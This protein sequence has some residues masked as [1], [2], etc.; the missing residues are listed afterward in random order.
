MRESIPGLQARIVLPNDS[1]I[2]QTKQLAV[3][4]SFPIQ[5]GGLA[6]ALMQSDLALAS[7]GTVTVECA[8]FGV[9]NAFRLAWSIDA[10]KLDE[11]L[12]RLA[13]ALE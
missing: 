8:F 3:P 13:R 4:A 12:A 11:A 10:G 6:E 7:T 9:P 2:A 5:A 1:L